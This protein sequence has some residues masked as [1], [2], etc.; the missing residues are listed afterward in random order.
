MRKAPILFAGTKSP[1]TPL[2]CEFVDQLRA[3][4]YADESIGGILTVG[5]LYGRLKMTA[6]VC[7]RLPKPLLGP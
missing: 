7:R 4:S 3:A 2:I 6:A 5:G 1:P